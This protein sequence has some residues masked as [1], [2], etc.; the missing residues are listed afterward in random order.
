MPTELG[1]NKKKKKKKKKKKN[2]GHFVY[3]LLEQLVVDA[4]M[5]YV[6]LVNH[7]SI[8]RDAMT[9]SDLGNLQGSGVL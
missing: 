4:R 3:S 6:S 1:A 2:R 5:H 7:Y 9:P 8:P